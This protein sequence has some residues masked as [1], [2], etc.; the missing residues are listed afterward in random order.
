[1]PSSPV[2]IPPP[3]PVKEVSGPGSQYCGSVYCG[4]PQLITRITATG[5]VVE[6]WGVPPKPGCELSIPRR[7]TSK[8]KRR[9]S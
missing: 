7:F 1:M 2:P 4:S 6:T 8:K 3:K 5:Q 9:A